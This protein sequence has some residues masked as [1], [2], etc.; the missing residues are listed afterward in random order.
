M[1]VS[2][3]QSRFM[4]RFGVMFDFGRGV[5]IPTSDRAGVSHSGPLPTGTAV[6]VG[7]VR[8]VLTAEDGDAKVKGVNVHR[9]DTSLDA[10]DDERPQSR[11]AGVYDV[12]DYSPSVYTPRSDELQ[13]GGEELLG[14]ATQ[15][16]PGVYSALVDELHGRDLMEWAEGEGE[17]LDPG[18]FDMSDVFRDAAFIERPGGAR[19]LFFGSIEGL[20][21]GPVG[22]DEDEGGVEMGQGGGG[23]VLWDVEE[24]GAGVYS[25]ASGDVQ[26]AGFRYETPCGTSIGLL[27]HSGEGTPSHT[28]NT[29]PKTSVSLI[30]DSTSLASSLPTRPCAFTPQYIPTTTANAGFVA[31][32]TPLPDLKTLTAFWNARIAEQE[33][34]ELQK[35]CRRNAICGPPSLSWSSSNTTPA[36]ELSE[37]SQLPAGSPASPPSRIFTDGHD[38][39]L[40]DSDILAT[41]VLV[42]SDGETE[43]PPIVICGVSDGVATVRGTRR[44]AICGFPITTAKTDEVDEVGVLF[45]PATPV[46][47]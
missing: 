46:D 3:R 44:N 1:P 9:V 19:E 6:N 4:E 16:S 7:S 20:L 18:A 24:D 35:H 26:S 47:G 10:N 21:A 40:K 17:I 27:T 43:R 12:A 22:F 39:R 25:S 14:G 28:N 5:Y 30:D 2:Y 34:R 8:D 29:S 37:E 11:E 15:Y 45:V 31:D 41:L 13:D 42:D 38:E 33:P 36:S 23:E 32:T